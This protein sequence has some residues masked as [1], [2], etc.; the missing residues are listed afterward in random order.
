[1]G[2]RQRESEINHDRKRGKLLEATSVGNRSNNSN[3]K[4]VF[5]KALCL[6]CS[7]QRPVIL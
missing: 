5:H 2:K 4:A 1:M 3:N 7:L 6:H